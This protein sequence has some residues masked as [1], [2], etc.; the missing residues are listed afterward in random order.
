MY[1]KHE[2]ATSF[3]IS[4]SLDIDTEEII[5]TDEL[6]KFHGNYELLIGAKTNTRNL[7]FLKSVKGKNKCRFYEGHTIRLKYLK[8]T[9]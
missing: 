4:L 3:H 6:C 8:R 1:L 5:K 2:N 9:L 7:I